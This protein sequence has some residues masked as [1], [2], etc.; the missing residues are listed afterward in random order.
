MEWTGTKSESGPM[1]PKQTKNKKKIL[2][3]IS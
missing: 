2:L 3:N 1:R